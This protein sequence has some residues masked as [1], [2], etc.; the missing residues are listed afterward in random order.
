MKTNG[1]SQSQK[2]VTSMG[3]CQAEG[4]GRWLMCGQNSKCIRT[5]ASRG[6]DGDGD[7]CGDGDGDGCDDGDVDVDGDGDGCGDGCGDDG[8]CVDVCAEAAD[9]CRDVWVF[10]S[11][12]MF[13][14]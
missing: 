1:L 11:E 9:L 12:Q 8:G 10:V 14:L 4:F 3:T 2:T 5:P 6:V 13:S 7:G